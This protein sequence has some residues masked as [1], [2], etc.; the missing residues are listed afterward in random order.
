MSVIKRFITVVI[1]SGLSACMPLDSEQESSAIKEGAEFENAVNSNTIDLSNKQGY[2]IYRSSIA[3]E[4]ANSNTKAITSQAE[5]T[6]PGEP[7]SV[8]GNLTFKL[9]VTDTE[10]MNAIELVIANV[11]KAFELCD[12]DCGTEFTSNV[13]GL[14]PYIVGAQTGSLELEVWTTNAE[15][16]KTLAGRKVINWQPFEINNVAVIRAND[17]IQITWQPNSSL[18]R[19]N[20]YLAA[21]A[22]LTVEN[23][24]S[25]QGGQQYLALSTPSLTIPDENPSAPMQLIVSGVEG[26]GESGFS[27][28]I[29]V[30]AIDG[31]L[32]SEPVAVSDVYE[33]QEDIML[34]GNVLDNDSDPNGSTLRAFLVFE[35]T[36][37]NGTIE[38]QENGEFEYTPPANFFGVDSFNYSII[39]E[40]NFVDEATVTITVASVNDLPVAIDDSF[41][42]P[43]N[44]SLNVESPG[45]LGNDFDVDGDM[46]TLNLNLTTSPEEGDLTINND[47]SFTFDISGNFAGELTFS[48]TISDGNGGTSDATVTLIGQ[49][50]NLSPAAVNDSYSMAEDDVLD[51]LSFENGVLGNDSDGN[52]DALTIIAD[53]TIAPL[54]GELNLKQ[55]GTFRYVPSADFNGTDSF[56]YTITDGSD[57]MAT[58]TVTITVINAPDVPIVA[59]DSYSIESGIELSVTAE[60][61]VLSNDS[62]IDNSALLVNTTATTGPEMGTLALNSDGSFTYTANTDYVGTDSFT[63]T[64]QNEGG[65]T[66]TGTVQILVTQPNRAPVAA[67]DNFVIE[68]D[69]TLTVLAGSEFDLLLNDSDPDGDALVVN[70]T[71]VLEPNNGTL[72]LGQDGSFTYQ[73]NPDYVGA[74]RFDYEISDSDGL[75][76]SAKV[77]INVNSVNDVPI[78]VGESF[79]IAEDAVLEVTAGADNNLLVNDSDVEDDSLTVN[80]T[81]V[82]NTTNGSLVLDESGGFVYTPNSHFFGVDS[83]T[84]QVVDSDGAATN[85]VVA[86]TISSVNDSPVA[87]DDN[88]SLIEDEMLDIGTNASNNLLANDSDI[89]GDTLSVDTTP[90]SSPSNGSLVLNTDGSFIYTPNTDYFGNDQFT[91]QLT[92]SLGATSSATASITISSVNDD[93]S[94][95]GESYSI[96]EDNTLTVLVN[97]SSNLLNN[98]TDVEGD[99]LSVVTTPLTS[100]S[101]GA[102]TLNSDGSF[103][104]VPDADYFGAD[105]FTYQVV[106]Q[107]GGTASGMVS[108]T[109]NGINDVPVAAPDSYSIS[110]DTSL[111]VA[112]EDTNQLLANDTDADGDTLTVS[113][114][115]IV[116]PSHGVL[117][118]SSNGSFTYSPDPNFFGEDSFTYEIEDGNGNTAEGVVTITVSNVLDLPVAVADNYTAITDVLYSVPEQIGLLSNDLNPDKTTVVVDLDNSTTTATGTLNLNTDGSFTYLVSNAF[119]GDVSFSYT[120]VNEAGDTSSATATITV[121]DTNNAPVASDDSYT[122][123]EDEPLIVASTDSNNLIANDSDADGQPLSVNLN[124]LE[125]PYNGSVVLHGAGGFTYTPSENF[126]GTDS[127]TYEVSDGSGGTDSATA[128]LTITSVNDAPNVVGESLTINEDEV[129]TADF[130]ENG[131]ISSLLAN[132]SDI[133]EDV[134]TVNITPLNGPENGTLNLNANGTFDYTPNLHFNGSDS[135][136]YEVQDANGDSNSGVVNITIDAVNDAP[137]A[138]DDTYSIDEDNVLSIASE[139]AN[140]LLSN[141]TDIESDAL[142][143]LTSPISEPLNGSVTLNADGSFDYVPNADFFGTDS[144]TYQISD[145]NGGTNTATA[146]ITVNTINDAPVGVNDTFTIDEDVTLTV[147]SIAANNLLANDTDTE[148]DSLTVSTEPVSGPISGSL[149]LNSDGSFVYIPNGEFFG[150]DS[151]TYQVNDGNGGISTAVASITINSVNDEPV[152][153]ADSFTVNEDDSLNVLTVDTNNLLANDTDIENDSLSVVPTPTEAPLNGVVTLNSDGSFVYTPNEN[154]F[155]ND[156]FTYQVTDGN[157]GIDTAIA[158]I[159][160]VSV[161]DIPVANDDSF[162]INEDVA[163]SI[164]SADVNILLANDTDVEGDSLS[165]NTTPIAAPSNGSLALNFDGSFVY[166]PDANYFGSDSFTYE[167]SDGNGGTAT[168]SVLITI[169]SINDAPVANGESF[170]VNEDT[171]LTITSV[172]ANNLLA[173]DTDLEG[174]SL[175]IV[176]TPSIGPSNGSLTLN[177]DGSFVYTPTADYEGSDSFVYEIE[178]GNGGTDTATATINVT[179]LNDTPVATNDSFSVNEDGTLTITDIAPNNLL[180]NDSDIDG[181]SLSVVTTPVSGPSNGALTLN[182]DGSFVYT[183]NANFNGSDSFTYQ[184]NDGNSATSNAVASI[185]IN[186]VNDTPVG[187]DDSFTIN[188]D[189]TL[190]VLLAAGDNLL[191]NDSDVDGDSLSVITTPVDS[192]DNGS[193]TLNADGSFEYIPTANFNGTD[194]FTYQLSDGNGGINTATATITIAAVNDDPTVTDD[195]YNLTEDGPLN[196]LVSDVDNLLANDSDVDGDSISVVTS[197]ISGPSNGILVLGADGSFLYT[198]LLN[199][200]GIDSFT[201]QVT[202]GNGGSASGTVTITVGP[203][204]DA[205][206][207]AITTFNV[208]ENSADAF[209]VG[210]IVGADVEGDTLSYAATSGDINLFNIDSST[211]VITVNGNGGLNYEVSNQHSLMVEV[212]DD[213]SPTPATTPVSITINVDNVVEPKE[214]EQVSGFG[215]D[216]TGLIDLYTL[217]TEAYFYDVIHH[218]NNLYFIGAIDNIDKDIYIAS[219][220]NDGD[221]NSLFGDNGVLTI[222]LGQ[223]EVG[224]A[225][226]ENGGNLFIAF[227]QDYGNYQEACLIKMSDTGVIND[228]SGLN[229]SGVRCTT[230]QSDYGISGA[231][232]AGDKIFV[233]GD[234]YNGSTYDSLFIRFHKGSLEFESSTPLIVDISGIGADDHANDIKSFESDDLMIV[235]GV[236]NSTGDYDSYVR[237]VT[238]EGIDMPTFD[239]DGLIVFDMSGGNNDDEFLSL[240]GV[241]DGSFTAFVVGYAEVTSGSSDASI[242]AIDETGM[243]ISSFGS[244]GQQ[245]FNIDGGTGSKE[246]EFNG[247]VLDETDNALRVATTVSY[248]FGMRSSVTSINPATGA[249]INSFGTAGTR[250]VQGPVGESFADAITMDANRTL[251]VAGSY[252]ESTTTAFGM[253]VDEAGNFND[254]FPNDSASCAQDGWLQVESTNIQKNEEI[255]AT[256]LLQN[257]THQGKYLTLTHSTSVTNNGNRGMTLTRY[258]NDGSLDTGMGHNGHVRINP[259]H[260][261]VPI[262]ML[263]VSTGDV[264]VFGNHLED[265]TTQGFVA[266]Y[267]QDGSLDMSFGINGVHS[268]A[269]L[270]FAGLEIID[271]ILDT[272]GKLVVV[273]EI[274]DNGKYGVI[275][276]IN[277]NGT[278]D[279][280]DDT[281]DGATQA[282]TADGF[283]ITPLN[284]KLFS[285]V[286]DDSNRLMVAGV[287]SG[288]ATVISIKRYDISGIVDS[289]FSS[290]EFTYDTGV[291]NTPVPVALLVDD[292]DRTYIVST[293]TDDNSD[294]KSGLILRVN[295]N[296]NLTSGFSDDGILP[297]DLS[298]T[299]ETTLMSAALDV[300]QRLVLVGAGQVSGIFEG[301]IA[302]IKKN[303]TLDPLFGSNGS[304]YS[305]IETCTGN[306]QYGTLISNTNNQIVLG[307]RC[308]NNGSN[309]VAIIKF[310]FAEQ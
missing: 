168:A 184:I 156:S 42:I 294:T 87:V 38:L 4:N 60:E 124:L 233:V 227:E 273:G 86:I 235:G 247:V 166:T 54:H 136:E 255:V 46:L 114:S 174:D 122:L 215:L 139:D 289:E 147:S 186:A 241:R 308:L 27:E 39:N 171:T 23:A 170:N 155:G 36:T 216:N 239:S 77:T 109:V 169:N 203:V 178:D 18:R 256:V 207:V 44:G 303:G 272:I 20:V 144:F 298:A 33:T 154:Y 72:I 200:N 276:R 29:D 61:G 149:A 201:Y 199:F 108:I 260:N 74:D 99:P 47:G 12:S 5:I 258:N 285:V 142:S 152:A 299:G 93:P 3:G 49:S 10:E 53:A 8:D 264:L 284:D 64:V 6:F 28:I 34:Q 205:P 257:G 224:K 278:L 220:K 58:A 110:E 78:V 173:N 296:G 286:E 191:N 80:T 118:L 65:L 145:G 59:P 132:D 293:L 81:P 231:E 204:N 96:D 277:P 79:V 180:A 234:A 107:N 262:G 182:A 150:S 261:E 9:S 134:L 140:Q 300:N 163:L 246:T 197:P 85:G 192:P 25:L 89:E 102:L 291:N 75:T 290:G 297:L 266:K 251:W 13:I 213:G 228:G 11:E 252:S 63:Y 151:F 84:Y 14:N 129:L 302:R 62:D 51:V 133:E 100:T 128:N 209:V 187:V 263:E 55:D 113:D 35:A 198:P 202:D 101:N 230:A 19:Y 190:T 238:K 249:M 310:N 105:S 73:P 218:D 283:L 66:A 221:V 67:D 181:D 97:D 274:T 232:F 48:Y 40:H 164:A 269:D 37:Q 82:V 106:D 185:T 121:I 265:D 92:D 117:S 76:S 52:N 254:C 194:T 71:P 244:S 237:Y 2:N 214:P 91:Y 123:N 116:E 306:E 240:G 1:I 165:V 24:L 125:P 45:V 268:T 112:V 43:L 137:I 226:V 270:G 120:M 275:A 219:Y 210:T 115:P 217:N 267:S 15:Q 175:S 141:D 309:D 17:Q 26:S 88:F 236:K 222:N 225:V 195:S 7:S 176:T 301:T 243:L 304:G 196:I 288:A 212:T 160:V 208:P 148:S 111:I 305:H 159:S 16:N 138:N 22:G 259:L 189:E 193:L 188:E 146:T 287:N 183:P 281:F 271:G 95:T 30:P 211:G 242:I 245:I 56:Q 158:T 31:G 282:F 307:M 50:E 143:V 94:V 229:D 57:L 157:G 32:P 90:I 21:E 127:F 126:F 253:S 206:T 250:S 295:E 161:N 162:T 103:S 119:T 177:A 69:G 70:T 83:F 172:A 41:D 280:D 68:E 248:G 167:I 179:A 135:F 153:T 104:Y 223:H 131:P 292:E 98:D 130:S 279:T